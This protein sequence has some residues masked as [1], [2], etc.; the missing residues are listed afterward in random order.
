MLTGSGNTKTSLLVPT[1]T[2]SCLLVPAHTHSHL[3]N[4][5]PCTV[6]GVVGRIEDGWCVVYGSECPL[7]PLNPLTPMHCLMPFVP[8]HSQLHPCT[9]FHI[10]AC[11]HPCMCLYPLVLLHPCTHSYPHAHLYLLMPNLSGETFTAQFLTFLI[12]S[13][14][15]KMNYTESA[16]HE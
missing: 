16:M 14:F 11:S 10:C 9:Q 8:A 4:S 7:A 12:H 13:S 5:P 1:H 3:C 6:G 2:L 15:F